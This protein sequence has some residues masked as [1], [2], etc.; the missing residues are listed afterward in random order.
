MSLNEWYKDAVYALTGQ[1]ASFEQPRE[2]RRDGGAASVSAG[3]VACH[4]LCDH[5]IGPNAI[6]IIAC[7]L[8]YANLW[9]QLCV[10]IRSFSTVAVGDVRVLVAESS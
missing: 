3:L 10:C 2:A 7:E 1:A 9:H 6:P 5:R 8:V 4:P